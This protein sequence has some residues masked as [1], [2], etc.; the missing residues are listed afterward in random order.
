MNALGIAHE[1]TYYRTGGG[2]EVN[3]VVE[4][5][6][7]C[8]AVEIK[9]TSTVNG[10]DLRALRDFVQEQRARLGVVITNDVAPRL[11]DDQMLGL[12][13]TH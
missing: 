7:G 5:N 6:F 12:P 8:V 1:Y 2:A 13:F 4:G 3:L 10:R 11:F 9:H